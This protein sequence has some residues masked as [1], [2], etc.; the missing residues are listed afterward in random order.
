[1]KLR[2][3]SPALTLALTANAVVSSNGDANAA[4]T[5]RVNSSY[6]QKEGDNVANAATQRETEQIQSASI[7]IANGS[8]SDA[9][10]GLLGGRIG[11]RLHGN[12]LFGNRH[13][14]AA[15]SG[16]NGPR[17]LQEITNGEIEEELTCHKPDTC[18]PN[19]CD[20]VANG[21]K[22]FTCASE[23]NAVCNGVTA[24]DGTEF[25][26]EGCVNYPDYYTNLYCPFAAC[27]VGG[28]ASESCGCSFYGE[29]CSIYGNDPD[30]MDAE[31]TIL[32]CA[33][34]SCCRTKDDDDGR[35]SCFE[36][37]LTSMPSAMPSGPTVSPTTAKPTPT[38][39]PAKAGTPLVMDPTSP[40]DVS[41]T[42]PTPPDKPLTDTLST[43][44]GPLA[45]D[46]DGSPA[47]P[48]TTANEPGSSA[49]NAMS[50]GIVGATTS[51]VAATMVWSLF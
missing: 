26:I 18:E 2:F 37:A 17:F 36:E 27:I 16:G 23:L 43:S 46:P 14:R 41:P 40:D 3:T 33:I 29:S 10:V 6:R 44:D 48:A 15:D 13:G 22:G 32:H 5:N 21:G 9:D 8:K 42:R 7:H 45:D 25:T 51:V 34:D 30:Y 49:Q 4:L 47:T 20:C 19:L 50:W 35:S 38:S 24:A 31:D 11:R 12:D 28:G 1:M 39:S